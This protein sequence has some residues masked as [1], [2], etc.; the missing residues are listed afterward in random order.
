MR[1]ILLFAALLFGFVGSAFASFSPVPQWTSASIV[2]SF[3]SLQ[4]ACDAFKSQK[5][6]TAIIVYTDSS[7]AGRCYNNAPADGGHAPSASVVAGGSA[8]PANSTGTT[9]CTCNSGFDQSGSA[10]VPHVNQCTAKTGQTSIINWTQGFSRTPDEGDTAAVGGVT[11]PPSSGA[12]CDGG[13]NVSAQISGPGVTYY[14]DQMPNAQGLYRRSVDMPTVNLGS[15]CTT[16]QAP[17]SIKPD[18]V[19]PACPGT[20]GTV[21]GKTVCVGTADKPVTTTPMDRPTTPPIAGNPA[22]GVIPASGEGSG[23][24]SAGRT[25]STNNGNS[26]AG[27]PAGAA[28]GGAGGSAGG[29]AAGTGT[30]AGTSNTGGVVASPGTGKEQANC[31]A[32]GQPACK[33]D[34]TGTPDAKPVDIL[35]A[36]NRLDQARSDSDTARGTMAGD[37]DKGFLEGFRSLFWA[38]P[39]ASCQPYVFPHNLG[40]LDPCD[41]VDGVR[42]L[43]AFLWSATGFWLCLGMVRRSFF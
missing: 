38:P 41:V 36:Q 35:V 42:M 13:C 18:A 7:T 8:C 1:R 6:L 14:V 37:S 32:P 39:V 26:N 3:D 40:T 17:A 43:M 5:S 11:P 20:V 19:E 29:T 33:I 34:E 25:P 30:G 4:A 27:G 10:C 22:A 21:N 16:S 23:S 24:G 9:T 2:G 12:M 31:G 15:E 28:V